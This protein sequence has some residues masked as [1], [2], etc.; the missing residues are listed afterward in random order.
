MFITKKLL[1]FEFIIF[2]VITQ[3][4]VVISYGRCPE[5]SVKNYWIIEP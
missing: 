2:W 1:S 3:P 5:M 4:V